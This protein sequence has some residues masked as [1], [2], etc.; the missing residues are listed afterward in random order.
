MPKYDCK[1]KMVIKKNIKLIYDLILKDKELFQVLYKYL[2]QNSVLT[3]LHL[4]S[5]FKDKNTCILKDPQIIT[6]SSN[7]FLK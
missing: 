5:N 7:C 3:F 4:L 1:I 2:I 6:I